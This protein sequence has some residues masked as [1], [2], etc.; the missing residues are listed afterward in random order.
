MSIIINNY[1]TSFNSFN[2]FNCPINNGKCKCSIRNDTESIKHHLQQCHSLEYAKLLGY[3]GQKP[4]FCYCNICDL[5]DKY[6]HSHCSICTKHFHNDEGL[7]EH[8]IHEHSSKVFDND[9]PFSKPN[10][11]RQVAVHYN[12]DFTNPVLEPV[13]SSVLEPLDIAHD[14]LY[15]LV[16]DH[17]LNDEIPFF[18]RNQN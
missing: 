18:L 9:G 8:L 2:I 5:I 7:H 16:D 11:E 13:S 17:V 4:Y 6:T 10:L 12:D 15:H 14:E 1:M 3:I